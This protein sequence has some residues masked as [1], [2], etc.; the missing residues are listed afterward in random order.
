VQTQHA[1]ELLGAQTTLLQRALAL[2]FTDQLPPY[3]R[4]LTNSIS[5]EYPTM[6][7]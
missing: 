2:F 7:A 6:G 5:R 3:V 1:V 4:P